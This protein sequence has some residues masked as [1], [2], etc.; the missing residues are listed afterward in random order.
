MNMKEL[1]EM[2]EMKEKMRLNI[3]STVTQIDGGDSH[4]VHRS[5]SCRIAYWLQQ[6]AAADA[7]AAV[8]AA[9]GK[10]AGEM[11]IGEERVMTLSGQG[12]E[13]DLYRTAGC[14]R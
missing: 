13:D 5:K 4:C 11:Q 9:M 10:R 3:S 6:S 2:K 14:G 7:A 8:A 12:T 1:K